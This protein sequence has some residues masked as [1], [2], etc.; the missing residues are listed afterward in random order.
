VKGNNLLARARAVVNYEKGDEAMTEP[1][2]KRRS[3]SG[4]GWT[5][6]QFAKLPEVKST[7]AVV[8]GAVER[9]DIE[10]LDFNG[11]K[12]ITPRGRQKYLE[13]WGEPAQGEAA[14]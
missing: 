14:E 8:R 11:V 1:R 10:A 9:G 5:I 7:A 3:P 12:R 6:N 4:P 2:T 13:V